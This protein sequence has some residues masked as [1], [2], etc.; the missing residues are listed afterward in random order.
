MSK[1]GFVL[2]EYLIS[3]IVVVMVISVIVSGFKVLSK[4]DYNLIQDEIMI[5]KLKRELLV[6]EI[7]EVNYEYIKYN[8]QNN[9]FYLSIV[10]NA[11]I[12]Q[13]GTQI[14]LS[15]LTGLSFINEETISINYCR[16]ACYIRQIIYE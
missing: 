10:D 5:Y 9:I 8:Y 2:I 11:L 6:S 1:K 3:L 15:G 12:I 13:P 14:V 16:K 7:I 4:F